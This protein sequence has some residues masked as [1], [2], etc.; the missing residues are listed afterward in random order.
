MSVSHPLDNPVWES[1]NTRQCGLA[2]GSERLRRYV[3]DLAPFAAVPENGVRVDSELHELIGSGE[4]IFFVGAAPR[5]PPDF[6]VVEEATI[7]QMLATRRIEM[8]LELSSWRPLTNAD[9]P[10]MIDLTTLVF[11]GF[12]RKRTNAMGRYIGINLGGRLAAMAGERMASDAHVEVSAVC[13][14]PKFV[15][16]GYAAALVGMLV[17]DIFDRGLTPYLHVS[18]NNSRAIRLY[19]RLGFV[20]RARLHMWLLERA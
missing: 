1:L 14:H 13:T 17:N 8:P 9:R 10:A 4:T 2:L 7:L 11:P 20:E 12:F 19:E 5:Q 18:E 6:S 16:R 3:A 15:G